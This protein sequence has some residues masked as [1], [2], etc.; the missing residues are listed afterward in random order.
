MEKISRSPD[1]GRKPPSIASEPTGFVGRPLDPERSYGV[2]FAIRVG[3]I[4]SAAVLV[5]LRPD[6]GDESGG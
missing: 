6:A 1:R 5:I 2:G 4:Q 3:G